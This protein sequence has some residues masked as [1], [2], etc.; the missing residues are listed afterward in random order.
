MKPPTNLK[1]LYPT[2]KPTRPWYVRWAYQWGALAI[3]IV[4]VL[5]VI[6]AMDL[7]RDLDAWI[8]SY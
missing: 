8:V 6:G 2:L 1:N 4:L 7:L 5:A 3:F